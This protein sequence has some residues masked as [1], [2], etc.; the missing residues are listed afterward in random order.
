MNYQDLLHS[1]LFPSQIT[2]LVTK[3]SRTRAPILI[4]GE[5][6]TGKEL[7]AKIIHYTGEWK[8]HRFQKRDCRTLSEEAFANEVSLLSKDRPAGAVPETL[9]FKE[10]GALSQANQF[11]LLDLM[12]ENLL[13][14]GSDKEPVKPLRFI[15]SSSEDLEEKVSQGRFSED[16]HDRFKIVVVR[17]LPLRDR[18][19]DIPAIARYLL[20]EHAQRIEIRNVEISHSVN[21]L[22]KDYWWPGNLRELEQVLVRS[23]ILSEGG[24]LKVEDLFVKMA[25]EKNGFASFAKRADGA[26]PSTPG[27]SSFSKEDKNLL[28]P[29][30]I[31]F[32][33]I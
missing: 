15:A 17:T 29:F 13:R 9:F 16:L 30:F 22:L 18:V 4:Q 1:P 20:D 32:L 26:A 10:V 24:D 2:G 6:G 8:H 12:E 3:A 33:P 23:A 7:I 5:R 11:R 14:G 31:N 25:G 27:E 28:W 21:R 19:Q